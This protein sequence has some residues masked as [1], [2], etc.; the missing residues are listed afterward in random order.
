VTRHR[1][2]LAL[3]FAL[4]LAL[5]LGW[6]IRYDEDIDG[7]RFALAVDRFDVLELRPHAPFYP[8]YVAAAKLC[9]A[10]GASPRIALG[11]VGALGG[12]VTVAATALLAREVAG[13]RAAWVAGALALASPFLW[14]SATKLTSDAAGTALTT[15]ALALCARARRVADPTSPAHAAALRTAALVLAGIELGVRLSY[16]PFAL[17]I[18]CAVGISDGGGMALLRRTRDLATGVVLWLVPLVVVA[19]SRAL[20]AAGSAQ[21]AGHFTRW[22]GSV[23]TIPSPGLRLYGIGWGVWANAL[24]GAWPDAP[25]LRWIG[26]PVLLLLGAFALSRV[27][28]RLVAR[29][30]EIWASALAYALWAAL[31]Q[32]VA[33]KPRHLL[34]LVPLMIVAL[35]SAS[36]ELTGRWRAALA[37]PVLL[38]AQWFVD[39]LGLVRAHML[40]SPAA[41]LVQHLASVDDARP[42]VTRELGRMVAEGAPR[43]TVISVGS[44]AELSAAIERAGA[45]GAFVTSEAMSPSIRTALEARD[46]AVGVA[47][48]RPRSRYVDALWSDLAL[49][50][51]SPSPS[52]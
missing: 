35:A 41:A 14:L 19:G 3:L 13:L 51:I 42:V 43:R 49:L 46:R 50:E 15:S 39:G 28:R 37:A 40:P 52:P 45:A 20:V 9:A 2:G 34:P 12:A 4:A 22:G 36:E 6:L 24:G 5:R 25:A 33:Y 38:S 27:D 10:A 30:S 44:D 21:A 17:A 18:A 32:N 47:F 31:F 26:A 1:L 29:H 11:V 16:F 7:L 48:A 23:I 8:V